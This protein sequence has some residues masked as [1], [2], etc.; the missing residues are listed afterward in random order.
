VGNEERTHVGAAMTAQ[1]VTV[2]PTTTVEDAS[3][4]ML[5]RKI[6]GLPV[7][8]DGKLVGIIT[9][10]DILQ[11]FLEGI[12]ATTPASVRIDLVH[13][14]D[15]RD[16]ADTCRIVHDAGGTVLSMGTYLDPWTGQPFFFLRVS[17]VDGNAIA[18]AL[19]ESNYTVLSVANG[20]VQ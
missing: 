12:G 9:T 16:L 5:A 4:M 15:S 13:K 1:P 8:E 14:D 7:V 3:Q 20:R 2:T 10:S 17:G 19:R 11:A 6:G 18:A